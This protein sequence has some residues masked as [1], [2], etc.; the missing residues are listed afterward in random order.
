L[1]AQGITLARGS[2]PGGDP[3]NVTLFVDGRNNNLGRSKTDGIDFFASYALPTESAGIFTFNVSGTYLLDY[4][5]SITPA[6]TLIDRRNF[7]FQ[8]LTFKARG[9]VAWEKGDFDARLTIAHVG[10]YTND[11]VTPNEKVDS[12]TPIDLSLAWTPGRTNDGFLGGGLTLGVEVRDLFDIGPPYVNLAPGVNGN[13]GYDATAASPI[14][15]TFAASARLR[16]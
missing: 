11:A 7:L 13:G 1:L 12:Y 6:G 5:V 8:P 9:S 10:G 14:G 15:R 16:W 4:K 3:N 2:F